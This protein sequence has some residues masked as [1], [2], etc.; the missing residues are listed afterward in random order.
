MCVIYVQE[1]S[2]VTH[3]G[4]TNKQDFLCLWFFLGIQMDII[5]AP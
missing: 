1:V 3:K 5:A 4:D 2:N